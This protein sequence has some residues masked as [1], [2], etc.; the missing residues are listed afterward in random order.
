MP[1]HTGRVSPVKIRLREVRENAGDGN[2]SMCALGRMTG[3]SASELS[4]YEHGKSLPS[5]PSLFAIANA[6]HVT[7]DELVEE[8]QEEKSE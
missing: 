4:R 5:V 3:I 7:M 6:L 2:I 1:N 8:I